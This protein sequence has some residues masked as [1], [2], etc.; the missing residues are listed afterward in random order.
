M[1]RYPVTNEEYARFLKESKEVKPPECWANREFNQPRQPVIGV[2]WKDAHRAMRH[3]QVSGCQASQS[4]SMR[5][6][7][8]PTGVTTPGTARKIWI[9]QGGTLRTRV[10]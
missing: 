6:A 2:S 5:V 7:V 10:T 8:V 9:R 4:G 3:G 1:G